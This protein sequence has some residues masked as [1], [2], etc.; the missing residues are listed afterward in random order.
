MSNR[1]AQRT[2][3]LSRGWQPKVPEGKMTTGNI[4]IEDEEN[5]SWV[6]GHH[7]VVIERKGE[8]NQD[9]KHARFLSRLRSSFHFKSERKPQPWEDCRVSL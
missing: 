7:R 2:T 9:K 4:G 6:N 8:K 5:A 3:G 1:I